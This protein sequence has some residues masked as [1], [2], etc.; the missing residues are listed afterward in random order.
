M[1]LF[2]E[3][4]WQRERRA[5]W[6]RWSNSCYDQQRSIIRQGEVNFS[7]VAGKAMPASATAHRPELAGRKFEGDGS[8]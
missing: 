2:E 7:H 5:S 3:D 8:H 1:A 4:A 6:W